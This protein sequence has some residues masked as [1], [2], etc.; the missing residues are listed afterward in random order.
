[1]SEHEVVEHEEWVE[2]RKDLL[3]EEKE[4][5]RL[6]DELSRHR[7]DLP[8][9]PVE[10]DYVFI[11][12]NGEETLADLFEGR[13]QL[14]V[15]HFMFGP[16]D[17]AGC[18]SCSFWV[19]NFDPN[20]VHLNARDVS[21][22]AISRAP[23]EKL[24]AYRKRMGWS[25]KWLSS[26]ENDFNFDYGVSFSAAE[27]QSPVYNYGSLSPG[28]PEREG[29]SVFYRDERGGVFHT[30]SSYARGIDLLNTA[31][32]YLDL[33]PKGRDEDGRSQ[34]WLRRHDEYVA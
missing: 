29:M 19:D 11:G 1:M 32:N 9:E 21:L 2:K 18:K 24:A 4:F 28:G 22:V 17:D 31:Y 13:S 25:F 34:F 3:K 10:N 16:D 8:W 27:E 23:F 6:R 20:V 33:V 14:V 5:T 12:P 15:Y 26:S 30:Y 7:R